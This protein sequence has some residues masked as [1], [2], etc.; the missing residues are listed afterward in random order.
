MFDC[1][2]LDIMWLNITYNEVFCVWCREFFPYN[3]K[4]WY[5]C[6]GNL[7]IT[8]VLF[9]SYIIC[10]WQCPGLSSRLIS[11]MQVTWCHD[12]INWNKVAGCE[13]EMHAQQQRQY[14]LF[15]VATPRRNTPSLHT[16]PLT[17][18]CAADV[19]MGSRPDDVA[20]W[21]H[22]YV[23][24]P[25][26]PPHSLTT[27]FYLMKKPF[28]SSPVW[29]VFDCH[30]A[31]LLHLSS[32]LNWTFQFVDLFILQFVQHNAQTVHQGYMRIGCEWMIKELKL[33]LEYCG[34]LLSESSGVL[35]FW[36]GRDGNGA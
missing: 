15:D 11:V 10:P 16:S 3:L 2:N 1:C 24:F 28:L 6:L 26:A 21:A 18:L 17:L 23:A 27:C 13:G 14:W 9:T 20:A 25:R 19:Q 35:M 30:N 22:S 32:I 34:Y 7:I 4:W 36:G 29:A 12:F 8:L 33:F 5:F 31:F